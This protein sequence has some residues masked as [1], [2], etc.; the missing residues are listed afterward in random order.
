MNNQ[1]TIIRNKGARRA[2]DF[3]HVLAKLGVETGLRAR[4]TNHP[5]LVVQLSTYM[6]SDSFQMSWHPEVIYIFR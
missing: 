4:N 5:V 2:N 1:A 3:L 6:L